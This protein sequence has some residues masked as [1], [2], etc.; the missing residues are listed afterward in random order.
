MAKKKDSVP[1][2]PWRPDFRDPTTLPD[3]KVVRTG[4]L[5]NA[6]ALVLALGILGWAVYEAYEKNQL[7]S[8]VEGLEEQVSAKQAENR[9]YL[10]L[11]QE[12]S[13][14]ARRFEE[15]REFLRAPLQADQFFIRL[16]DIQPKYSRL[17]RVDYIQRVRVQGTTEKP[18]HEL[19]VSGSMIASDEKTET[20]LVTEF[21][22]N[23][24]NLPE[25]KD[26]LMASGL[27]SFTRDPALGVFHYTMNFEL[28]RE[29]KKPAADKGQGQ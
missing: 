27:E 23:I 22:R 24:E 1:S 5:L 11:S 10:R 9:Q 16:A 8:V 17:S 2:P 21:Q 29:P 20:Q 28:H 14:N 3:I 25:L 4:F 19:E 13:R 7:A 12:F 18:Y 15:I 26:H 6:I